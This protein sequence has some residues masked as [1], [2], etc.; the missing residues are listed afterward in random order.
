MAEQAVLVDVPPRKPQDGPPPSR[1]KPAIEWLNWFRPGVPDDAWA[2]TRNHYLIRELQGARSVEDMMSFIKHE[3]LAKA[4]YRE[5]HPADLEARDDFTAAEVNLAT[6]PGPFYLDAIYK[7]F[8]PMTRHLRLGPSFLKIFY[9]RPAVRSLLSKLD[10]F[11]LK[12]LSAERCAQMLLIDGFPGAGK[13]TTVWAWV[14]EQVSLGRSALFHLVTSKRGLYFP[15]SG[16]APSSYMADLTPKFLDAYPVDIICVDGITHSDSEA[17]TRTLMRLVSAAIFQC[18]RFAVFTSSRGFH[19]NGQLDNDLVAHKTL[20]LASWAFSDYE[21][22]LGC[23]DSVKLLTETL[24][25][26]SLEIEHPATFKYYYA[27]GNA[28]F[29]FE[30]SPEEI[31]SQIDCSVGKFVAHLRN[32]ETF[33]D[34]TIAIAYAQSHQLL[35]QTATGKR[36]PVSEYCAFA[37]VGKAKQSE[38]AF[39]EHFVRFAQTLNQRGVLGTAFEVQFIAYVKARTAKNE[40]VV[41]RTSTQN[42]APMI[43]IPPEELL[44]HGSKTY[45]LPYGP[46]HEDDNPFA[47]AP[48][49]AFLWFIPTDPS[50]G[51]FD[52]LGFFVS[53]SRQISTLYSFQCTISQSHSMKAHFLLQ[54]VKKL[55]EAGFKVDRVVHLAIVPRDTLEQFA[56][57]GNL[58]PHLGCGHQTWPITYS[59]ASPDDMWDVWLTTGLPPW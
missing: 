7:I 34:G 1:D 53:A 17:H 59:K 44:L 22:A 15:G 47:G 29:F 33:F 20:T 56:W 45:I 49:N 5:L 40:R 3:G 28:R 6:S 43:L 46:Y 55:E 11:Y 16:K 27:G 50:Q 41:L 14:Q 18:P 2:L 58:L 8:A 48:T 57:P 52:L 24:K 51:C 4:V 9:V 26:E 19:I 42:E 25:H 30:K 12:V 38:V 32:I 31:K 10:E 37:L 35:Q 23:L 13:T 36:G 21:R 39:A 54:V